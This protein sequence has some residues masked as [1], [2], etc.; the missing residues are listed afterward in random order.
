[1]RA[2]I[3][4]DRDGVPCADLKRLVVLLQGGPGGF[5]RVKLEFTTGDTGAAIT[6]AT[7]A[8]N[9][10][11]T[12]MAHSRQVRR[13]LGSRAKSAALCEASVACVNTSLARLSPLCAQSSCPWVVAEMCDRC[14]G[15]GRELAC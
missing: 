5:V 15:A 1:M 8:S 11:G 14:V 3:C 9:V 2:D 4:A 13:R 10:S 6:D 7:E 12:D